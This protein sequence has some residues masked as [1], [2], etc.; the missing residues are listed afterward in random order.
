MPATHR[1]IL[2]KTPTPDKLEEAVAVLIA[3]WVFELKLL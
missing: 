3:M 2:D 1:L